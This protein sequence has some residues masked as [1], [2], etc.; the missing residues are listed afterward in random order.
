M[1]R[2]LAASSGPIWQLGKAFRDGEAGR[3]HNP[4]FTLLEWYRPGWDHHRL[5]VEVD[6]LLHDILNTPTGERLSYREAFQSIAGLDPFETPVGTL[7]SVSRDLVGA[8]PPDL[9]SD[10]DSWLELLFSH[11]LE[12]ELGRG[13]PS[14]IHDFPAS[15]AALARVRPGDP[16]LAER[17]EVFVDG[18]EL[19]NG[20]HELGDAAEQRRRF[21]RDLEARRADGLPVPE[22]DERLLAA[23]AEGLPDCAGVALG[24]D[25]LVMLKLGTTDISEVIAFPIDRA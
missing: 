20:F 11:V 2:L 4:E 14:F 8:E 6:E 17:F 13:R 5:M 25:R 15:Q 23:L 9:G 16:A 10:R 19:A 24:V 22:L 1:K 3:C 7:Q 18:V 21:E 12:P